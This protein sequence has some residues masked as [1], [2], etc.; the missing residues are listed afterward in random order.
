MGIIAVGL[1]RAEKRIIF[2]FEGKR[3]Q[4]RSNL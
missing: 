4:E 1:G 3:E 2:D